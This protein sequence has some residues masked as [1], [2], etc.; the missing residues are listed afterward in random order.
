MSLLSLLGLGGRKLIEVTF[1]SSTSWDVPGGVS[2]LLSITGKG[3]DGTAETYSS[4]DH[5]L[6]YSTPAPGSG[7]SSTVS[8]SSLA[9]F[10]NSQGANF[11]GS[12]DR[13]V[14]YTVRSVEVDTNNL[15]NVV[16]SSAHRD[17]RGS[18]VTTSF[19]GSGNINYGN[20]GSHYGYVTIDTRNPPTT[21]ASASGFTKTFNGGPG[22]AA[23]PVTY[24]NVA[25]TPGA[26][27]T[28]T[29]PPGGYITITYYQ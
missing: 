15:C 14:N 2:N 5:A 13:T 8:I 23:T 18:G 6:G 9:S 11:S 1:D 21:G 12:G 27:Y 7:G 28:I 3:Q 25:V 4:E 10:V 26:N 17:V 16:N 29:V 22:G 24:N 19:G 20:A